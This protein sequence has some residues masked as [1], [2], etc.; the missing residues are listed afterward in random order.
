MSRRKP[1]R[2]K[3]LTAGDAAVGK[4]C[5]VKRFCEGKFYS[6]YNSTVG[7][8][9]GVKPHTLGAGR[10]G[11]TRLNVDYWDLGGAAEYAE[12]RSDFWGDASGVVFVFDVADRESFESL[13]RWLAEAGRAGVD[14]CGSEVHRGEPCF[15]VA[16]NKIDAPDKRRQVS[17]AEAHA[18]AADKGAEYYETSAKSG[19]SVSEVRAWRDE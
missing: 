12:I 16:G 14:L 19:A 9:Y 17:E 4:S 3:I 7:V 10:G 11:G 5:L 6:G 1:Q 2:I 13:E 8:D 15:V 18:W